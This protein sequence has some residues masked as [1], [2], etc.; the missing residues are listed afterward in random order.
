M[1]DNIVQAEKEKI[2][3]HRFP[4]TRNPKIVYSISVIDFLQ[5]Y[6]FRKQMEYQGRKLAHPRVSPDTLSV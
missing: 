3:P 5:N 4:S 6:N 1:A 2:D